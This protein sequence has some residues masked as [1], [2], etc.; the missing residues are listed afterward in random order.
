MST[1]LVVV[2]DKTMVKFDY[3]NQSYRGP[4]KGVES[5]IQSLDI[6]KTSLLFKE[7]I[8]SRSTIYQ[9]VRSFSAGIQQNSNEYLHDPSI[10]NDQGPFSAKNML[11]MMQYSQATPHS[12]WIN[13]MKFFGKNTSIDLQ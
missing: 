6:D 4:I 7:V 5:F 9:I 1:N 3:E 8:V 13:G 10:W 11:D 2:S 12:I